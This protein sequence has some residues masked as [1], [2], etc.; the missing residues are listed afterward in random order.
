[1]N[2]SVNLFMPSS[3]NISDLRQA[4]RFWYTIA[5]EHYRAFCQDQAR[6]NVIAELFAHAGLWMDRDKLTT[7]VLEWHAILNSVGFRH[8]FG[9]N[10]CQ[11]WQALE[12]QCQNWQASESQCKDLKNKSC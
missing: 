11:N 7:L 2:N 4:Q 3:L 10:A 8:R 5:N 1:M 12:W 9:L 6:A